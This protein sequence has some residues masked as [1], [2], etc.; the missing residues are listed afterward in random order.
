MFIDAGLRLAG[1][2]ERF[3]A[4]HAHASEGTLVAGRDAVT[5]HDSATL[6]TGES[7]EWGR[8][9]GLAAR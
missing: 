3:W 5:W 9:H 7:V 2:L 8:H 4:M 1:A 6:G